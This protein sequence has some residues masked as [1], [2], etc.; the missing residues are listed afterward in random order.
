MYKI[1]SMRFLEGRSRGRWNRIWGFSL[2]EA[3]IW[4]GAKGDGWRYQTGVGFL[5]S[6][7]IF[8]VL[9]RTN[10]HENYRALVVETVVA[11]TLAEVSG[12]QA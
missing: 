8:N 5:S 1:K 12:S 7:F 6:Q 9:M 4:L 11:A 10:Y 2:I 3:L